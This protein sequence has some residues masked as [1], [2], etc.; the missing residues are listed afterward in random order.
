MFLLGAVS[1]FALGANLSEL[2]Y[3][4]ITLKQVSHFF[5]ARK[6]LGSVFKLEFAHFS[7]KQVFCK[8]VS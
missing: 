7:Y 8:Q 5:L 3:T 1:N 4:H 6:L 2:Y